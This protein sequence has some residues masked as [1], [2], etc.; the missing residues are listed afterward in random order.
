MSIGAIATAV[1]W[2]LIVGAGGYIIYLLQSRGK[3]KQQIQALETNLRIK[4]EQL[5]A[6]NKRPRSKSDLDDRLRKQGGL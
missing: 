1:Q 3:M 6:V 4:E 2:L 5:E